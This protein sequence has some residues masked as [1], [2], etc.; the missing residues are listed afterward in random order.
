VTT[1]K[2]STTRAAAKVE[3]AKTTNLNMNEEEK[4]E[5]EPSFGGPYTCDPYS[6]KQGGR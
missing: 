1:A 6:I 3:A 4:E 2:Q 5:G